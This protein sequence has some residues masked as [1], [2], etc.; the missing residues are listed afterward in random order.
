MNIGK[1]LYVIF[2]S[3][4]EYDFFKFIND[5]LNM[6]IYKGYSSDK[7]FTVDLNDLSLPLYIFSADPR[8]KDFDIELLDD[9]NFC[10]RPFD[11][12][13]NAYPIIRYER[14]D[15]T[16]RIFANT[17][18]MTPE[19]KDLITKKFI[20]I[21]NWLKKNSCKC[22]KEGSLFCNVKIYEIN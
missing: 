8:Y 15:S 17:Q 4:K 1:Q 7:D 2:N 22:R 14:F 21:D 5:E 16:T 18:S 20:N 3:T 11:C 10:I 9:G 19:N 13:I 6:S 12:N